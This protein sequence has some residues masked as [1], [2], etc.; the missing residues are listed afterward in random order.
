MT[1]IPIHDVD[2]GDTWRFDPDHANLKIL[3]ELGQIG[4]FIRNKVAVEPIREIAL[5][6]VETTG[7]DPEVDQII[8]LAYVVL[9]V[10][11]EDDIVGIVC[12][13]QALC[14]PMM[15]IP[16][17]ISDF[18]IYRSF[19]RDVSNGRFFANTRHPANAR[20]APQLDSNWTGC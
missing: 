13:D 17:Q 4:D 20:L 3:R 19:L 10:D 7:M 18:G 14:D 11:D 1:E 15:P 16:P 6:D 12:A 8:D 2:D 9:A 5:L